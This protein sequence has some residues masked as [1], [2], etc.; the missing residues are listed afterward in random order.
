MIKAECISI[1]LNN[2]YR[3]IYWMKMT[4][5]LHVDRTILVGR[6]MT[7]Y[8]VDKEK[9]ISKQPESWTIE[10]MGYKD[11]KPGNTAPNRY[12]QGTGAKI[13]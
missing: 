6:M 5:F 12:V 13:H 11:R 8:N 3:A 10:K 9:Y 7:L 1:L 4:R 2:S